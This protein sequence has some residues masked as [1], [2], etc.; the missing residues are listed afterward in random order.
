MIIINADKNLGIVVTDSLQYET[1]ALSQLSDK[2]S[3]E[4]VLYHQH[5]IIFSNY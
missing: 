5:K 4:Q 3:Y 1:E 2:N